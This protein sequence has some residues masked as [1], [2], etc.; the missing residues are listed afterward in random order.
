MNP[1]LKNA[2]RLPTKR[3]YGTLAANLDAAVNS[4]ARFRH[5][6]VYP[7]TLRYWRELVDSARQ[8]VAEDDLAGSHP[9]AQA[10][11]RLEHELNERA[12]EA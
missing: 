11:D 6:K 1:R 12:G 10:A 4:A 7:D 8:S 3:L 9:I 2:P 5:Q